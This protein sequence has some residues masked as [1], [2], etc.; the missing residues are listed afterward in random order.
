MEFIDDQNIAEEI[1]GKVLDSKNTGEFYL[2][3]EADNFHHYHEVLCTIQMC[4]GGK[5][6]LFDAIHLDLSK[7]LSKVLKT[8]PLWLHG[9]DY[10]LYLMKQFFDLVPDKLQDTQIAAR[11]CG[12]TKFG[13]A[14]LVE[15]LCG[16]R[17][18]KD[19]QR[20]DWT[21]RPLSA[22]MIA[23]AMN[24]VRY[25]P[26][27]ADLLMNQLGK[28]GRIKWFEESCETLVHSVFNPSEKTVKEK[29]RITGTGSFDSQTLRFVHALYN[30]RDV[31]AREAN[32]P[33]FK[34]LNNQSLVNW[35]K[36]LAAGE[37]ITYPK[38]IST[39]RKETLDEAIDKAQSLP[40]EEWP[41]RSPRKN[42]PRVKVD[43]ESLNILIKKRD[44]AAEK[45]KIE[46]SFIASRKI[47]ESIVKDAS[48]V[49]LLMNWQ[50]ELLEL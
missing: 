21:R 48:D 12:F 30:W 9:C 43:E 6:Y 2:D 4:V 39:H 15:Q 25:L 31:H 29:W 33:P 38:S 36:Q 7:S 35:S 49:K 1:L 45:L 23:Y 42:G 20:A 14:P 47:L 26:Q 22:K 41:A 46:S 24:D 3:F 44:N 8:Q 27:I 18:P 13:Y 17:L 19:S 32:K 10:D 11:L 40:K 16:V 34:I 5:F 28:L 37:R 50:R